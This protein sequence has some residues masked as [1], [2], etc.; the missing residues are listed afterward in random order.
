MKPSTSELV[1]TATPLSVARAML[2]VLL[3]I[4]LAW[5]AWRRS[6]WRK[7]IGWLELLRVLVAVGIA[8]TLNQPEWRET[9][10]PETKPLVAVLHDLSGSME[11]RDGLDPDHPAG[12]ARTRLEAAAP[13]LDPA[14][15][16]PLAERMDVVMEPFNRSVM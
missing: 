10:L 7:S 2:F 5:L 12:E 3:V 16:K 8:I 6:G 4:V 9:F 15:W 11:T 1:F 13:L 14:L